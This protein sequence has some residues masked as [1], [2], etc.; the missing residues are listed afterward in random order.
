MNY[1]L[2]EAIEIR[3]ILPLALPLL[4]VYGNLISILF[5]HRLQEN[6]IVKARRPKQSCFPLLIAFSNRL[7]SHHYECP[8]EKIEPRLNRQLETPRVRVFTSS[9]Y[10]SSHDV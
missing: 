9:A 8:A 1:F 4:S 5:P 2:A 7:D 6:D 3:A 10:P